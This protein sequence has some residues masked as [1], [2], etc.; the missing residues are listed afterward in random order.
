MTFK[1]KNPRGLL[2]G[3]FY[4]T[5]RVVCESIALNK[6]KKNTMEKISKEMEDFIDCIRYAIRHPIA[7]IIPTYL[8][9]REQIN[10]VTKEIFENAETDVYVFSS[11]LDD[12]I[13]S[14]E[15]ED[16]IYLFSKRRCNL[17]ILFKQKVEEASLPKKFQDMIFFGQL[18]IFCGVENFLFKFGT[19]GKLY[20]GYPILCGFM[21]SNRLLLE[22]GKYIGVYDFRFQEKEREMFI[23]FYKAIKASK[24]MLDFEKSKNPSH[25]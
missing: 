5:H 24:T 15:M 7:S 23:D 25:L 2:R 16:S 22:D 6:F 3:F 11:G 9:T 13:F 8:A 12:F 18:R 20:V 21:F 4:L 17:K 19:N 10:I 1:N 14:K